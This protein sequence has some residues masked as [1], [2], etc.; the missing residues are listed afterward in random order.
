MEKNN[1]KRAGAKCFTQPRAGYSLIETLVVVLIIGI[2][3][4]VALPQYQR[5][6]LKSRFAQAKVTT[7]RLADAEE[8]YYAT[9]TT[10][11]PNPDELDVSFPDM[12]SVQCRTNDEGGTICRAMF[13]WGYCEI[14]THEEGRND[15]QCNVVIKEELYLLYV[16]GFAHSQWRTSQAACVAYGKNSVPS[17][18]DMTYQ[19]CHADTGAESQP[20]GARSVSFRY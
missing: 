10:Y 11:T 12:Q 7:R 13:P 14:V 4:A 9:Y 18:G 8:I 2:L 5:A 16:L 1:R 3:T 15:A 19:I 20:W 6:V 17:E